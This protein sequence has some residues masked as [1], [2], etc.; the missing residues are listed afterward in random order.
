MESKDFSAKRL[1]RKIIVDQK[2]RHT[3]NN[4]T[5]PFTPIENDQINYLH[6][7]FWGML[8]YSRIPG[9]IRPNYLTQQ[10]RA[11]GNMFD[12]GKEN[13]K[14]MSSSC[15]TQSTATPGVQLNN[16]NIWNKFT[17]ICNAPP[18]LYFTPQ[19]PIIDYSSGVL[20][21][22][23][24]SKYM[25]LLD[26]NLSENNR[27]STRSHSTISMGDCGSFFSPFQSSIPVEDSNTR[28]QYCHGESSSRQVVNEDIGSDNK[29]GEY[30]DIG[31]PEFECQYCGAQMWYG[32]RL[33]KARRQ[34]NPKFGL[35]CGQGINAASKGVDND[36]DPTLVNALKN[37]IDVY[38]P[39]AQSF[40]MTADMIQQ[41]DCSNVKL[42]LIGRRSKDGRQYN[43]PTSSEVVGI[44]IG[45]INP[46]YDQRD[47]V[48]DE[49]SKGLQLINEYHPSYLA[50]QYPL[51]FTYGEDGFRNDVPHAMG[52]SK[53]NKNVTIREH[54][55]Y[56][57]QD[58]A[59]ES[60]TILLGRRLFHQF[61]VDTC[62]TM[63]TQRL[64][65]IRNNQKLLRADKYKNITDAKRKG[66]TNTSSIGKKFVLPS[67][68]TGSWRWVVQN[69]QDAMAISRWTGYPDLFITFTCN[70]K[71]PEI[72]RFCKKKGVKPEDRPDILCRVFKMKLDEMIKDLKE[73][74]MFGKPSAI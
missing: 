73:R 16:L 61:L 69:Y 46:D 23:L 42:R 31:D 34:K 43:L 29:H 70:P 24:N 48:V 45:D 22:K 41:G 66:K 47:I 51:L 14:P 50:F 58:R 35:C 49:K 56:R 54:L 18:N 32:E 38:N 12:P 60:P 27:N 39:I 71:W 52:N 10:A 30:W 72:L 20:L 36:F 1:Q 17:N 25:S 40:R 59:E 28:S 62:T 68:H 57:I 37:M 53:K 7:V 19:T 21:C 13:F 64:C 3:G 8:H 11:S 44:I 74:K 15:I 9:V 4:D 6:E 5:P 67:S 65:F 63:E 55:A 2:R 33:K 26:I